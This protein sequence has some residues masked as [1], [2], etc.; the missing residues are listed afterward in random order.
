MQA[1]P[2]EDVAAQFY[3]AAIRNAEENDLTGSSWYQKTLEAIENLKIFRPDL[4]PEEVIMD[5]TPVQTDSTLVSDSTQ[6]PLDSTE[7]TDNP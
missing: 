3:Q 5:T 7:T 4:F 6:V 2:Y 1:L